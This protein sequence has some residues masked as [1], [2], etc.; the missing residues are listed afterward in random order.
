MKALLCAAIHDSG[1]RNLCH[2]QSVASKLTHPMINIQP[3]DG[4]DKVC[5]WYS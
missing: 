3:V 1:E 5:E 4:K 2:I